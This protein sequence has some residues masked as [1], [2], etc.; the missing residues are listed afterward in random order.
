MIKDRDLRIAA[1]LSG[2]VTAHG[3]SDVTFPPD[4][5]YIRAGIRVLIEKDI[6][7]ANEIRLKALGDYDVFIPD[8]YFPEV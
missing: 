7:T 2:L 4:P 8:D 1:F 5:D 3:F 6:F